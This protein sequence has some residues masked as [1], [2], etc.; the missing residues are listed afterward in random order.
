MLEN[1][2]Y[3][4]EDLE[5]K[6]NKSLIFAFI[7]LLPFLPNLIFLSPLFIL[8]Y[9]Y[10]KKNTIDI[11]KEQIIKDTAKAFL[12]KLPDNKKF[13]IPK[14]LVKFKKDNIVFLTNN[15]KITLINED[16]TKEY[17]DFQEFFR[18]YLK[19]K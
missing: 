13:W 5:T 14:N 16:D 19:K 15:L 17:I 3:V 11:K 18:R 10:A 1:R 2:T 8:I 12:I 6:R 7:I 9:V 4:E